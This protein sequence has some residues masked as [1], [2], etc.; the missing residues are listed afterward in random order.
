[1]FVMFH[2]LLHW[3]TGKNNKCKPYFSVFYDQWNY[4]KTFK[5]NEKSKLT[6]DGKRMG[7]DK[8]IKESER[9]NKN[10]ENIK[11]NL[12]YIYKMKN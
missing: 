6:E 12:L 1:M 3:C 10:S 11:K 9:I 7:T 4:Y 5:N 8:I 2:L